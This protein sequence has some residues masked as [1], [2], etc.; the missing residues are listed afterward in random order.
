VK[1][2][3]RKIVLEA[4]REA[5]WVPAYARGNADLWN[6]KLVRD[7]LVDAFRM[8]RK[9]GGH[10][11]PARVKA[12]W[13]EFQNFDP[14]DVANEEQRR[15]VEQRSAE[16]RTRMNVTRM[17]AV[18]LGADGLPPWMD[19]VREAPELQKTLRIFISSE[20]R[21]DSAKELCIS[22][23]WVYTTALTY[24]DRAAGIIAQRLNAAKVE[25]W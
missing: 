1:A 20:L 5:G 21:G 3:A 18:L 7:V 19:L 4:D 14:G 15:R 23:G 16:Y 24:R 22:H 12:Y 8:L 13:P 10:V 2:S 9:T 17:E 6:P 25:V 11:G